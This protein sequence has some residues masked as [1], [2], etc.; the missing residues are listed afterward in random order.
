M[1]FSKPDSMDPAA[2]GHRPGRRGVLAGLTAAA[3]L[4][5]SAPAVG[6]PVGRHGRHGRDGTTVRVV[7]GASGMRLSA[8]T[9]PAG[10]VTVAASTDESGQQALG[11]LRLRPDVT[12]DTFLAHYH[13][14]STAQEPEA[15]REALALIDS[16]AHYLGGPAVTADSG[17]VEASWVL[18]PGTYHL[19]NYTTADPARP[20][21]CVRELRVGPAT[22]GPCRPRDPRHVI[23]P[24]DDGPDADYLC[25]RRLP[26]CGDIQVVNRTDQLN[27]VMLL[28]TLE[29]TPDSEIAACMAAL[30]EGRQ[31]PTYP[32]VGMPAGLTPLSP[33]AG[34]VLSFS[35]DPG[36]YLL[37]SFISD[38]DTL[39][40]RAFGGM[41]RQVELS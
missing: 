16:E 19:L 21:V 29:G 15:R 2:R 14:A 18:T 1:T 25:A 12:V 26:A 7:A 35:L 24:Y 23:A 33:G 4:L 32:F 3:V 39:V 8:T 36:P 40:K 9:V 10:A 5:P 37:T 27:E 41:W 28:R 38:R 11:L 30:R 13:Q 6:S 31:P 22:S 17:R 34:A 20:E